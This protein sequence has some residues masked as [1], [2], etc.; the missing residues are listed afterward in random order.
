MARTGGKAGPARALDRF[1][2]EEFDILIIGGGATGAAIAWD[3]A[4][5]GYKVALIEKG[6]FAQATSGA[7]S[8]LIH[9]GLRYLANLEFGLV[10]EA[11]RERRIWRHA[12]PHL[13]T[14]LPFLVPASGQIDK[15]TLRLGLWLYDLL[16]LTA[17]SLPFAAPH[18]PRHKA[19]SRTDSVAAEPVLDGVATGGALRYYDCQMHMPERLAWEMLRGAA[20]AGATILNYA[21]LTAFRQNGRQI[22]G[23]E[24]LDH[25]DGG[26]HTAS[27]RCIVN[28]AGPWAD[29][30]ID[31]AQ[32]GTGT[33]NHL[34]ATPRL[35]HSK[36]IHLITR[37]LSH[38][39]AIAV[40]NRGA[41]F[42]VL[43]W[44]GHSL[45][46]TTDTP[47][48]GDPD[49]L[50]VE[51]TD[52]ALLLD[53]VN[54]GLPKAR[55]T[56]DDVLF[57]YAGLRPLVVDP[58]NPAADTY[59]ASRGSEILDHGAEGGPAGLISAIGGKW[60]T[61]R[62]LAEKVVNLIGR[63]LDGAPRPS[64]TVQ[65]LLPGGMPPAQTPPETVSLPDDIQAFLWQCYGYRMDD[66]LALIA[67]T[68]AL[69]A[70]LA[71]KRPEIGAQIVY[72]ARTEMALTLADAV[73]RR[74]GLCTLGDPG[75]AA[76]A[77]AADLMAAELGWDED[78]RTAQ[79]R[80]V[81]ERLAPFCRAA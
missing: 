61:S 52:I 72:A 75:A 42:F 59:G 19:F 36:G 2:R 53:T 33:Q 11:L 21:E 18:L 49:D 10:R 43:P 60:T 13:V 16:S 20:D 69:A 55:L 80:D 28:A 54:A 50:G 30:L 77:R 6:D 67:Q 29:R 66:L 22:S 48:T 57:G 41:H 47:F 4:L 39:H 17:P 74:T 23:A 8:K 64:L 12:A 15:L 24:F 56:R 73:F 58:A 34:S 5:R 70:P 27:A 46:A 79:I 38:H 37:P 7:S 51:E 78:T 45:L 25:L 63:Q 71:D 9:G 65:S 68:P 76:L 62:S 44:R 32:P 31:M 81:E 26:R 14:A 3:A 1:T 35:R 40:L